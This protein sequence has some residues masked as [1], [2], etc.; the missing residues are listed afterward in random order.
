MGLLFYFW[1]TKQNPL[2]RESATAML[3]DL[4]NLSPSNP[5]PT[6]LMPPTGETPVLR[7]VLTFHRT[8]TQ[9]PR[10][11]RWV[12]TVSLSA[13]GAHKQRKP[14]EQWWST[15]TE[16]CCTCLKMLKNSKSFNF[17]W[18]WVGQHLLNNVRWSF[19]CQSR[20][21][22]R[23]SRLSTVHFWFFLLRL[24]AEHQLQYSGCQCGISWPNSGSDLGAQKYCCIWRWREENNGNN[25]NCKKHNYKSTLF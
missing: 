21:D 9:I 5:G 17:R 11:R 19:S 3:L 18:F 1:L 25:W 12:R 22:R 2:I 13:S 16:V 14:I 6:S 15:S 24:T 20:C 23:D 10:Q 8:I 7:M 4:P